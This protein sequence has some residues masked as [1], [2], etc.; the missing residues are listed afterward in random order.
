[1]N[2]WNIFIL[3]KASQPE[4][5]TLKELEVFLVKF[6]PWISDV[7]VVSA[8]APK[9]IFTTSS[10]LAQHPPSSLTWML[11]PSMGQLIWSCLMSSSCIKQIHLMSMTRAIQHGFSVLRSLTHGLDIKQNQ[12]SWPKVLVYYINGL[13]VYSHQ[14][15]TRAWSI[16]W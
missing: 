15:F 5:W 3:A 8:L 6:L 7:L 14:L 16:W 10:T 13:G 11:D 2:R 4:K 1:M 12:M 9:S